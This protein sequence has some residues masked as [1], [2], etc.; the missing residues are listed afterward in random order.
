MYKMFKYELYEYGYSAVRVCGLLL[1]RFRE[2]EETRLNKAPASGKGKGAEPR[3]NQ[4]G[5]IVSYLSN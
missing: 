1:G 5:T 2:E 3:R 4:G